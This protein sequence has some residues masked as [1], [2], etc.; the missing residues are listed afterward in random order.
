M[1]GNLPVQ[2][3]C[4]GNAM[5]DVFAEIPE[6]FCKQ[7]ALTLPVQHVDHNSAAAILKALPSGIIITSGGGAANTAKAAALLGIQT[8]FIGA[9]GN[10]HFGS[11]FK[12]ELGQT[13]VVLSLAKR[14]SPTGVF[15]SLTTKS[16]KAENAEL[17]GY[18][19]ASPSAALELDAEDLDE[20]MFKSNDD[21]S[22]V[23]FLEGFL[24][25]RERLVNCILE[26]AE[27][28]RLT[29][30]VDMGIPD[31]AAKQAKNIQQGNSPFWDFKLRQ[32]KFPLIVF[33][34][35]AEAEAFANVFDTVW[36]TLFMESSKVSSVCIIVKLAELGA[37]VFTGGKVF[38]VQTEPVQSAELT[39]AGD[40]FAAGFLAAWLSGEGPRQCGRAGNTAAAAVLQAP[41]TKGLNITNR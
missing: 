35:K 30:A 10:D 37:S 9:A 12:E 11:L 19:I 14:K 39:G 5:V 18:I 6:D 4:I 1:N 23:L 41:G 25:G 7:F 38:H 15:I 32:A 40:A 13:G 2:L 34:N 29:L 17:S 16:K 22:R 24:L 36:E 8:A 3:F 26:L 31:I 28:Y 27:K 21:I 33:F 20:Q